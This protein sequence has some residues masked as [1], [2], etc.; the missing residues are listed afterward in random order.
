M[1]HRGV[2]QNTDKLNIDS[3]SQ[4]NDNNTSNINKTPNTDADV[5]A[6]NN[7]ISLIQLCFLMVLIYFLT[8]SAISLDRIFIYV[9]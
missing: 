4:A 7:S 9:G 3:A 6:T 5:D 2:D 8:H 1:L